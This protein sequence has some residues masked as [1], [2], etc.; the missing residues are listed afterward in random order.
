MHLRGKLNNFCAGHKSWSNLLELTAEELLHV[1]QLMCSGPLT[2][3]S[4]QMSCAVANIMDSSEEGFLLFK[5]GRHKPLKQY[6]H[7][8]FFLSGSH[9]LQNTDTLAG[10][11][12]PL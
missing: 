6:C 3:F 2:Q 12:M 4:Q 10:G 11:E 7:M 5:P 9:L 1:K 8:F